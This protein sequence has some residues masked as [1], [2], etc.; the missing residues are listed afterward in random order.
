MELGWA[1][2]SMY[3]DLTEF[4]VSPPNAHQPP[5][6]MRTLEDDPGAESVSRS[7]RPMRHSF[8]TIQ[9]LVWR[10]GSCFVGGVWDKMSDLQTVGQKP[11]GQCRSEEQGG[12]SGVRSASGE[13]RG[14]ASWA[15]QCAGWAAT[16]S[17]AARQLC[18]TY[19]GA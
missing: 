12:Q 19:S 4:V 1:R 9:R 3:P 16:H 2:P 5:E 14:A 18:R 11:Q 15:G 17:A 13:R 6:L 7:A 8:G 10:W